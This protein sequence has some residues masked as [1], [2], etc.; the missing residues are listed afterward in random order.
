MAR[1]RGVWFP[2]LVL[3]ATLALLV[4][5]VVVGGPQFDDKGW[6]VRLVAYPVLMLIA[7]AVWALARRSEPPPYAA[8]G[9][10][11]LP[12]LSDTAANWLDLFRTI[13]W[14]DDASHFGHWALLSAGLGLLVAPSVRPRWV[15]VPLVAGTGS[16]LAL[17]WELGEY[18]LFIRTGKEAGGAYRDTLGDETLGT[19]GALLAGLVVAWWAGRAGR[20]E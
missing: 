5:A 3:L 16:L 6:G 1:H 2:G 13:G 10:I 19:T 4:A 7:P 17:A 9:L 14:W 18:A 15:L 8:F 20:R 12:F 11:M